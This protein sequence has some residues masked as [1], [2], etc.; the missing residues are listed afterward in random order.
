MTHKRQKAGPVSYVQSDG[1][2]AL[3]AVSFGDDGG[4][5]AYFLGTDISVNVQACR[6]GP[7]KAEE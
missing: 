4:S 2:D 3:F 1:I 6:N 7:K 5:E